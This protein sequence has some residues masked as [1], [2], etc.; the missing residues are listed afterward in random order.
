M[1]VLFAN[2]QTAEIKVFLPKTVRRRRRRRKGGGVADA[3][4]FT[5]KCHYRCGRGL[6]S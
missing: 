3:A 2:E 1:R 5:P 4:A 6:P